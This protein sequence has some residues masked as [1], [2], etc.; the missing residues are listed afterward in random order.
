MSDFCELLPP[1]SE[2]ENP[3][4]QS[5]LPTSASSPSAAEQ[6]FKHS[7]R[8]FLFQLAIG[9]N[10]MVGAVLAVPLLGYVL[11]PMFRKNG[12]YNAWVP[13]GKLDAMP[14][15]ATRLLQF[16][17]PERTPTDGETANIPVWARRITP[18]GYEVFAI[19]C[20]HLGCPVRWFEQSQLFLCPCHGGAYY[21][22]GEVAAGPP[23]RG[24]YKY[25]VRVEGDTVLI[26]AGELPTLRN[27]ACSG[28]KSRELIQIDPAAPSAE[29]PLG[30]NLLPSR[31]DGHDGQEA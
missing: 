26:H 1:K 17:N 22:T 15:G 21:S 18:T 14:V 31:G 16:L 8:T 19:N 3:K 29:A 9:M 27:V 30:Y 25:N 7:R 2:Q 10:A 5:P 11:S 23:P 24:L 28:A 13:I 6:S 4:Q 20:A 12:S